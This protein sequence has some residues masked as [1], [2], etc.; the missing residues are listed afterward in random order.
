MVQWR[1]ALYSAQ[2]ARMSLLH[3][4]HSPAPSPIPLTAPTPQ[5]EGQH[6]AACLLRAQSLISMRHG[7]VRHDEVWGVGGPSRPVK[8]LLRRMTLLLREYLSSCDLRQAAGCLYE[9]EEQHFYHELVGL[10]W[11]VGDGLPCVCFHYFVCRS[12]WAVVYVGDVDL[13]FFA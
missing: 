3:L 4:S 1:S 11:G 9:L 2:S 10:V 6:G 12:N 8:V 7:F 5:L 13:N